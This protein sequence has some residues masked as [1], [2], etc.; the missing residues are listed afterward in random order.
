MRA[1]RSRSRDRAAPGGLERRGRAAELRP[2]GPRAAAD[3][4]REARRGGWRASLDPPGPGRLVAAVVAVVSLLVALASLGVSVLAWRGSGAFGFDRGAARRTSSFP[5]RIRCTSVASFARVC[6][7]EFA[8]LGHDPRPPRRISATA[9]SPASS[10][11]RSSGAQARQPS[12]TRSSA[13]STV[14]PGR[15]GRGRGRRAVASPPR[16]PCRRARA[17]R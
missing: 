16:S 11:P 17:D 2:G 13:S 1:R 15:A 3:G 14:R 7:R 8:D 5:S 6:A 4:G 9:G 12:S 10:S